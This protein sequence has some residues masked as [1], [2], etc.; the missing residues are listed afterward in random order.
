ML[1]FVLVNEA[2]K[3][4]SLLKLTLNSLSDMMEADTSSIKEHK[5]TVEKTDK[6]CA[7]QP[8]YASVSSYGI[9]IDR[10]KIK[11]IP[12]SEQ[13]EVLKDLGVS[14]YEQEEFEEGVLQQVDS[15]IE[16][17]EWRIAIKAAEKNVQNVKDEIR[18][19]QCYLLYMENIL[20]TE[21][22]HLKGVCSSC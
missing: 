4:S 20:G 1:D 8:D 14:A 3:F 16:E 9:E 15:A 2:C 11:C 22:I 5:S 17:R 7:G 18:Y 10:E 6:D 19:K 12:M 21:P 13:N